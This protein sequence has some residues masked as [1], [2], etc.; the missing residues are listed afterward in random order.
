[1]QEFSRIINDTDTV[2]IPVGGHTD[3]TA[4]VQHIVLQGAQGLGIGCRQLAAEQRVVALMD[5]LQLAAGDGEQSLQGCLA[6]TVHGVKSHTESFVLDGLHI[7]SGNDIVQ[8]F[9]E[10]VKFHHFPLSHCLLIGNGGDGSSSGDL[11]LHFCDIFL[12]LCGLHFIG[13]PSASCEDLDAV[14]DRRVMAGCHHHAVWQVV[15]HHII[16]DKW[17]G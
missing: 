7:H 4:S 11:L 1:M 8:I 14:I 6:H 5:D 10:R 13:I 2:R 16:H 9:I 12:N 3:V 15:C 17:C